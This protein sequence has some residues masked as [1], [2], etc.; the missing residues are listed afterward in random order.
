MNECLLMPTMKAAVC[1]HR[2]EGGLIYKGTEMYRNVT[3]RVGGT[4][5][6]L[7]WL[8]FRTPALVLVW[9]CGLERVPKLSE[10]SVGDAAS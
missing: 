9:L 3:T 6:C 2:K 5:Q 7:Q 8:W 4:L 1:L 10:F